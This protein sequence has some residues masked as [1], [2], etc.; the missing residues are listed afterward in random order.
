MK[1]LNRTSFSIIFSA[2]MLICFTPDA[3]ADAATKKCAARNKISEAP[4][5]TTASLSE[6]E[7]EFDFDFS[8]PFFFSDKVVIT[9][10]GEADKL[11]YSGSFTKEEMQN[12]E[13]LKSWLKRSEFLLSVD[14]QHYY[15]S[16][17]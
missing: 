6:E 16:K 5:D 17:K 9:I 11:L 13:E 10:Y 12:N 3:Q 2:L 15:F 7:D 8:E 4:T 14:N 1:T